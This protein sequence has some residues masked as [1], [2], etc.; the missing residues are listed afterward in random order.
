MGH[1]TARVGAREVEAAR[2]LLPRTAW[3][4]FDEMPAADRRH[5]LDV[6][7]RLRRDGQSDP[8]LLVAALLH[9]CAKGPRMRL[10][11]RVAGVLLEAAAPLLLVRL[12]SPRP[13]S[14]RHGLFLYLHHAGLSAD[15]ALA[16]GCSERA[17]AFIAGRAAPG[18]A[19][20][21]DALR[22]ADEA[23]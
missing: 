14:W 12:A 7:Q 11:H 10:W 17:V 6:A 16:A 1:L 5:G 2:G 3:D 20:L 22:R 9:D 13:G 18:D 19:A 4:L 21:A 15:A 23:S 8:D